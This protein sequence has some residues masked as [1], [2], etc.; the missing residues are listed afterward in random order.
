MHPPS[1]TIKQH[2][3]HPHTRNL[4]T[5]WQKM[6]RYCFHPYGRSPS[7]SCTPSFDNYIN[8]PYILIVKPQTLKSKTLFSYIVEPY[9]HQR[10]NLWWRC[11]SAI[12]IGGEGVM[13]NDQTKISPRQHHLGSP[14]ETGTVMFR[15]R[16]SF[17]M[18]EVTSTL[19]YGGSLWKVESPQQLH[20]LLS[21]SPPIHAIVIIVMYIKS[22]ILEG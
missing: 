3:I 16:L 8:P 2:R 14:K 15:F 5:P 13:N 1:A 11:S 19:G 12:S 7:P 4:N 18:G 22:G 21:T 20:F 6:R 17:V 9:C 10:G